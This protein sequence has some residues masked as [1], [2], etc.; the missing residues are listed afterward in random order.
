MR[1]APKKQETISIVFLV[2]RCSVHSLAVLVVLVAFVALVVLVA[3]SVF[4]AIV[5]CA[6][7]AVLNVV[8]AELV[9]SRIARKQVENQKQ[10]KQNKYKA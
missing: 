8:V 1:L 5:V 2:C 3:P 6:V 10:R 9:M 4:A 7:G